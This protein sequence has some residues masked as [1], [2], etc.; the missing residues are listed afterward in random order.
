M[1]PGATKNSDF[2]ASI[3]YV[4][5]KIKDAPKEDCAIL[6]KVIVKVDAFFHDALC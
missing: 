4:K 3:A 6:V 5:N 2:T 1:I